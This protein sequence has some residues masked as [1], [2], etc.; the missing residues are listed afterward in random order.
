MNTLFKYYIK[1]VKDGR[2]P[3]SNFWGLSPF[4]VIESKLYGEQLKYINS[5][6]DLVDLC[7]EERRKAGDE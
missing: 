3:F 7:L 4:Q 2:A 1:I 5:V 6:N